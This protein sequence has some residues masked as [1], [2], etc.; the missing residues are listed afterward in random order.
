LRRTGTAEADGELAF[1]Q[2]REAVE[3]RG[4]QRDA[5]HDATARLVEQAR[6][7][8]PPARSRGAMNAKA[9]SDFVDRHLLDEAGA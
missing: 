8:L 4:R 7:R 2:L 3:L 9:C 6:P 1:E 5:F